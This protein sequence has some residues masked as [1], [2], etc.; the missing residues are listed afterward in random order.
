MNKKAFTLI[1][2]L[3]VVLIIGILAAIALPQ[4]Q[5]AVV[6]SRVSTILPVLRS[7]KDAEEVYY[8]A[9]GGYTEDVSELGITLPANCS[10]IE[11][12][13]GGL[14]KCGNLFLLDLDGSTNEVTNRGKIIANYCPDAVSSWD[15]CHSVRNFQIRLYYEHDTS[16]NAAGQF[17]CMPITAEGIKICKA[18]GADNSGHLRF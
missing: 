13:D 16:D 11:G 1:E 2:L 14:Y 5:K 18:L 15:N 7:I 8:M 3:V 4:Y 12:G 17:V 9:N 6:K 10:A